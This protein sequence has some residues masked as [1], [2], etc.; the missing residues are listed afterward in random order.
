MKRFVKKAGRHVADTYLDDG[1]DPA[2]SL[3]KVAEQHDLNAQ[4][5]E[6]VVNEA[7]G[8]IIVDLQDDVVKE[9][10]GVDRNFTFPTVKTADVIKLLEDGGRAEPKPPPKETRHLIDDVLPP[11]DDPIDDGP[12]YDV[13]AVVESGCVEFEFPD[14]DVASRVISKLKDRTQDKRQKLR[15]LERKLDA[16]C[17][18][19][20]KHARQEVAH[21]TPREVLE[22]VPDPSGVI[23]KVASKYD[24]QL[25]SRSGTYRLNDDHPMVKLAQDIE[26]LQHQVEQAED[27]DELAAERL[28]IARREYRN[29]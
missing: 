28:D 1:V 25:E 22:E 27:D 17:R 20:K 16:A 26:T 4:E 12:D 21:G 7:N 23:D 15:E 14:R 19:L 2:E 9:G 24:D 18:K 5:I 8:N 29:L 6:R 13:D 11:V 10:S 3:A